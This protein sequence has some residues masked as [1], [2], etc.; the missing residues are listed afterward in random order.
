[1]NNLRKISAGIVIF[2]VLLII[3]A[4]FWGLTLTTAPGPVY[5][6]VAGGILFLISSFLADISA[7]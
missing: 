7:G 1:M 5:L 6:F 2:A 4:I 3:I